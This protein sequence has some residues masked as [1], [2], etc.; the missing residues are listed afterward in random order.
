MQ[1]SDDLGLLLATLDQQID[2]SNET[3]DDLRD[4]EVVHDGLIASIELIEGG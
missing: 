1:T 4:V 2:T 3:M